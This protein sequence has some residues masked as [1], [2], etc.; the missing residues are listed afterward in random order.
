MIIGIDVG[1]ANTKVATSDGSF[2]R[3]IYA[4]LWRSKTIIYDVLSDV[5]RELEGKGIKAV[6]VVMTGELCDRFNTKR[7]GALYIKKSS[8]HYVWGCKLSHQPC[9]NCETRYKDAYGYDGNNSCY[10]V[11]GV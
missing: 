4:P 9:I 2:A 8:L 11:K 3:L 1:G 5:K 7:E 10:P 6:G